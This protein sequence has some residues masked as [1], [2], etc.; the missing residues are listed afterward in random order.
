MTEDALRP[1]N[2]CSKFVD[3]LGDDASLDTVAE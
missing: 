3:N 2:A 1:G